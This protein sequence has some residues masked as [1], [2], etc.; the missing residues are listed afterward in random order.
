[1]SEQNA[2]I[3]IILTNVRSKKGHIFEKK[4]FLSVSRFGAKKK[5]KRA[6]K[7]QK[8][9]KKAKL[10]YGTLIEEHDLPS[11]IFAIFTTLSIS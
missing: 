2:Y 1:M 7:S 4:K 11:K 6:K 9:S 5:P 8:F 3:S 10:Q